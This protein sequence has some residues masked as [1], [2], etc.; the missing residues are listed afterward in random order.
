MPKRKTNSQG[1]GKIW[2]ARYLRGEDAKPGMA[3]KGKKQGC[4]IQAALDHI[5]WD[6]KP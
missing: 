1:E 4:C 3:Q 6:K 5:T 2:S